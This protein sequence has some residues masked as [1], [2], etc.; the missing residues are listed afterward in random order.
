METVRAGRKDRRK[1]SFTPN[2][3]MKRKPPLMNRYFSQA[4]CR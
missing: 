1:Y 3:E 4:I 2:D